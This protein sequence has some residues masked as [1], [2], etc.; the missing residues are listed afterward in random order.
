[1]MRRF[2]SPSRQ[3]MPQLPVVSLETSLQMGLGAILAPKP[4]IQGEVSSA[5]ALARL[6]GVEPRVTGCTT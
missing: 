6:D 2:N 3:D 1:M 5:S 4:S